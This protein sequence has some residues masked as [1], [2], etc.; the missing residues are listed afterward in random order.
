M[1][2]SLK[3]TA[4]AALLASALTAFLAGGLAEAQQPGPPPPPPAG[5]QPGQPGQPQP[6]QMP[7]GQ[8]RPLMRPQPGQNLPGL[9]PGHPPLPS[10]QSGRMP[11][12]LPGGRPGAPPAPPP[13]KAEHKGEEHCPGH[14]PLDAPHHVNWWHGMLMANSER[15]EKGG[16]VNHLLFRY[17][18]E[19]NPCD[20][21]NEP[22]P[23]LASLLNFGLLAFIVYSFGKKPIGE[24]LLKRKQTIM[25]DIDTATRLREEAEERL[26]DYEQ[27]FARIDETL[28]Q[29]K[30]ELAAQA[31]IEKKF[32]LA[33][34]E[35]RRVRMRRDAEF[36]IEQELKAA[37]VELLHQA[38]EGAV[39]AAE[40][41]LRKSTAAHDQ[42][43][44]AKEYL[45]AIP[46][47]LTQGVKLGGAA[48]AGTAGGNT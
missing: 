46:A 39:V 40:E 30:G 48:A 36:R 3:T 14:G 22:P 43:R 11:P 19:N 5:A 2:S 24:A 38:V 13:A 34:A 1:R 27:K 6:G 29:L 16:F 32:I 9:P 8:P 28:E 21:K 17:H 37:R 12:G 25:Q 35:E 15:A 47:A 4:R 41:L 10:Q 23:F 7:P 45:S 20:P 26:A 33:E 18:N 44:L 31:D 42:E